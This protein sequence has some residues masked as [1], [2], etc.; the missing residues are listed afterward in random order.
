MIACSRS[1]LSLPSTFGLRGLAGGL[2]FEEQPLGVAFRLPALLRE[3]RGLD[4]DLRGD[5][6]VLPVGGGA[7]LL[8]LLALLLRDLLLDIGGAQLPGELL[9]LAGEQQFRRNRAIRRAGSP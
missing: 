7:R 5:E 8:G 1:T 4:R 2:L 6:I 9:A 3:L